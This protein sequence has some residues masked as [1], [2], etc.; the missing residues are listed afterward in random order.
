[1]RRPPP[2]S[3]RTDTLFPYT[4]LFRSVV[5]RADDRSFGLVVDGVKDSS[6]IVV[7]PLGNHLKGLSTFAGATILG[8]GSVALILDVM[9][10]AQRAH[11]IN[12]SRD[13]S[14]LAANAEHD[15]ASLDTTPALLLETVDDGRM[16]VPLS[17]VDRLEELP[18]ASVEIGR[19][20]V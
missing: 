14:M 5:L 12:E 13:R 2:R 3:T 16:A 15:A 20:P 4:T 8:D 9:G 17:L 7:K 10:L 11:V 19:A 18:L 1:M 6:E